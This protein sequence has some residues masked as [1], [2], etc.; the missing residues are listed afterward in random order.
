MKTGKDYAQE[1]Q[2]HWEIIYDVYGICGAIGLDMATTPLSKFVAILEE[3]EW[4][5]FRRKDH[6]L[7]DIERFQATPDEEKYIHLSKDPTMEAVAKMF[8]GFVT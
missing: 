2:E 4:Y 5:L 3:T 1:E 7:N 6:F 8:L